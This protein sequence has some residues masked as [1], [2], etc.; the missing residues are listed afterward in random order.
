MASLAC[1]GSQSLPTLLLI[2]R[3]CPS[4]R[5]RDPLGH[6]APN[7]HCSP[8]QKARHLGGRLWSVFWGWRIQV[9]V[10]TLTP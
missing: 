4:P 2:T 1:A 10:P 7:G 5:P 3:S 8:K 9:P 6:F